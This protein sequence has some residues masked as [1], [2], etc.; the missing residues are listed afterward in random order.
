VLTGAQRRA[1]S[2]GCAPSA[3]PTIRNVAD[4]GVT[5]P[6]LARRQAEWRVGA[7]LLEA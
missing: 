4:P 2:P 5:D 3:F 1:E 6:Y 7:A